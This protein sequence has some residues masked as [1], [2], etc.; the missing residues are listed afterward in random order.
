MFVDE[1]QIFVK[2]GD[3]GNGAVAFHR[4]KYVAA[5]GPNGG[6]GGNGGSVIITIDTNMSTLM[7]FRYKKKYVADN[8]NDGSGARMK[9]KDGEDLIIKVPDGTIVK[10]TETNR[11][12]CDLSGDNS[13]F[14]VA[15]GGKG[16]W[17]NARFAT[18]TRQTPN[19][20]KAGRKGQVREI[21]LELKLIAD[22]GLVGFPNVGKSTLLSVVSDAKPKIGNY[23]FTTLNPNLGVVNVFDGQMVIA[24][25][26][27][28]IEGANEGVGLGHDFLRH[29]ERTRLLI[30]MVDVSGCEGRNPI[31]DF[32][33]INSELQKYSDKLYDKVQIVAAN[34]IDV[35]DSYLEE[36]KTY[37]ESLGLEFF[38]ISA[39]TRK[40]TDALIKRAYTI[41]QDIPVPVFEVE[42]EPI[43]E[44]VTIDTS[45]EIE[46]DDDVYVVSGESVELLLKSTNFDDTESVSYFQRMLRKSGIIAKL[47][48]MGIT[49]GDT[50]RIVDL[51]FDY[52][53]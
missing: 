1:A 8:G 53:R 32:K 49:D 28:I 16:G 15:H 31:D 33:L 52:Y 26:P 20:A 10:D 29:I 19:F 17:G 9:G 18:P 38:A 43:L 44:P 30:H 5:G 24:D 39:A 35:N 22:V 7:D 27:G 21:T 6:D 37:I 12:I 51:E 23:H 42:A 11:I 13:S 36:F 3:G 40:G 50:V 46:L 41:L 47:E 48:E 4:E 25:I 34:K 2:G 14:I 45:F